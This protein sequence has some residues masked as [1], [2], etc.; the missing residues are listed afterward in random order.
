MYPNEVS[1]L[2]FKKYLRDESITFPLF[3]W[4][5]QFIMGLLVVYISTHYVQHNEALQHQFFLKWY[6][7][8]GAWDG[9]WYMRI[10][11]KGYT[12]LKSTAFFPI[13]PLMIRMVH[14]VSG[15]SYFASAFLVSNISFMFALVFL[16][17]VVK[18][19]FGALISRRTLLFLVVFPSAMFYNVTYTESIT[20]LTTV[21]FF[22]LLQKHKWY[23]AM[24][25]GFIATG[26]HDLGVVLAIPAFLYLLKF[27]YQFSKKIF[28]IRFFS[29]SIIGLSLLFYMTFLY[30]NF[31]SFMTFVKAQALWDRIP[32]IPVFNVFVNL[33]KLALKYY[34]W[35][36]RFMTAINGLCTLLFV[37]LGLLMFTK[38]KDTLPL[39]MKLFFALTLFFSITSGAF[40]NMDTWVT[41]LRSASLASYARF[42]GVI[43]PGFIMM[44]RLINGRVWIYGTMLAFLIIKLIMLGMFVAGYS[45]V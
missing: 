17:R 28:W 41:F 11:E 16:Y 5:I 9:E 32:V 29:M 22:Y 33:A 13:Y 14:S 26:V 3:L 43:F 19:L 44:A 7:G 31:G 6:Q 37:L 42:M 21:L 1:V 30:F 2:T 39:D 25:A 12:G 23:P 34:T 45:V 35:D 20:L 36:Y 8:Y 15:F 18:D 24:F 27:R 4:T 40:G 38:K 10:A